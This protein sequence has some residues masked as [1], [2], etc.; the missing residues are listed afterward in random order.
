M[1]TTNVNEEMRQTAEY[2]IKVARERFGKQLD[3]TEGSLPALENLIEQAHQQ[4]RTNKSEG[5]TTNQTTLNR[6]ASI[7]GSYFANLFVKK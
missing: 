5:K 7:W 1:A 3:Y 4:L 6:T 2:A